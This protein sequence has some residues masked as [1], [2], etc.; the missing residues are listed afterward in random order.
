M[1]EQEPLRREPLL[2]KLLRWA[3][4]GPQRRYE[5]QFWPRYWRVCEQWNRLRFWA[6]REVFEGRM[7][8]GQQGACVSML[9]VIVGT[10]FRPLL[11]AVGVVVAAWLADRLL[12]PALEVLMRGRIG[13]WAVPSGYG[14]LLAALAQISGV[15]L[16]LYFT[17]LGVVASTAWA[18]LPEDVRALLL[19]EQGGN[20][21]IRIVALL[22][23]TA[24]L[25]LLESSLGLRLGPLSLLFITLL[26][27][28]SVLAFVVL[29]IRAFRF[30]D[31]TVLVPPLRRDATWA[32]RAATPRGFRCT[33]PSFQAYY[34]QQ[35]EHALATYRRLTVA[36]VGKQQTENEMIARLAGGALD[37]LG[38][39]AVHKG[40]IPTDS[41]WFKPRGRHPDW[42]T[43][44]YLNVEMALGT[45]TTLPQEV[46]PD[47]TWFEKESGAIVLEAMRCLLEREGVETAA[48]V[49][50]RAQGALGRLAAAGCV[51]EAC[52]FL[53]RLRPVLLGPCGGAKTEA[54][55]AQGGRGPVSPAPAL[56][57][58]FGLGV[59]SV[60]LGFF[61]ALEEVDAASFDSLVRQPADRVRTGPRFGGWPRIVLQQ[62]EQ[63][64]RGIQFEAEVEGRPV[65]PRW[66]QRQLVASSFTSY[67]GDTLDQLVDQIENSLANTADEFATAGKC[68]VAAQLI[69]RGLEA[70]EKMRFHLHVA[71]ACLE[72]LAQL[73][74]VANI[75]WA[76]P[77]WQRVQDRLAR[78]RQRMLVSLAKCVIPLADVPRSV[79]LPDYFG[80]AYCV[81]AQTCYEALA[82]GTHELFGALFP[83]FFQ[84]YLRAEARLRAQLH[85]RDA[86]TRL[87]FSSEP[88]EDVLAISGYALVYTELDQG[89]AWDI[90]TRTW[91]AFFASLPTPDVAAK[92]IEAVMR[93]MDYRDSF[94]AILPRAVARTAWRQTLKQRLREG[95]VLGWAYEA[96]LAPDEPPQPS[97]P[98][99]VVRGLSGS[100]W[101]PYDAKDIFLSTYLMNRPEASGIRPTRKADEWARHVEREQERPDS[102]GGEC[103]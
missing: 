30:F 20:V 102:C 74:R 12:R 77:D 42:L 84:A 73:R 38:F 64:R 46:E 8:L 59:T 68:V 44:D 25:L 82:E 22:G 78:L 17:V 24:L 101:M 95:G 52:E 13:G 86:Q 96:P 91:N 71:E 19:R 4:S 81:L 98:S 66:Y 35:A 3:R 5:W 50:Y 48:E 69:Q 14:G 61:K 1:T 34:Q 92:W 49:G 76:E 85:H 103:A 40:H 10:V 63:V 47:L 75:P 72:R 58:A 94:P 26:G 57:D 18:D 39:Y 32:I 37:V 23:A 33:D 9:R 29:G 62:A 65:S 93:M 70:C 79:D 97:H 31:P 21:Y 88:L 2:R 6:A 67:V 15:F 99:V 55:H 27:V 80:Q 43:A 41:L 89:D 7:W 54:A 11:F 100:E 56:I 53:R 83:A 87:V 36:A 28:L 60:L 16:G 45:A 51:D 90:V